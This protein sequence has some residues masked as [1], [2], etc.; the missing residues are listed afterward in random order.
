[1]AVRD[2]R[3]SL[4]EAKAAYDDVDNRLGDNAEHDEFMSKILWMETT[5]RLAQLGWTVEEFEE[6]MWPKSNAAGVLNALR[7]V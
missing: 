1:L 6:A 4:Q 5:V 7:N 2:V 3:A